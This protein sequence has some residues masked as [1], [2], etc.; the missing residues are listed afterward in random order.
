MKSN[1]QQIADA[2]ALEE[3]EYMSAIL[4]ARAEADSA[5]KQ[6]ERV[7]AS[8]GTLS[9]GARYVR[10]M[11][12][13]F[14]LVVCGV[15]TKAMAHRKKL[16]GKIPDLLSE[17]SLTGLK[18]R[19]HS[20]VDSMV[21]AQANRE[22]LNDSVSHALVQRAQQKGDTIKSQITRDLETLR[23]EARIGFHDEEKPVVLN[24]SNSTVAALNLGTVVGDLNASVQILNNEGQKD[25]AQAV[26]K[27]AEEVVALAGLQDAMRKDL[28]EHLSFISEQLAITADRRK[29]GPLKSSI[30]TLGALVKTITQL[31]P[32][33]TP[34]EHFLK[35][36]GYL[37]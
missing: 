10:E 25:L 3:N 15:A 35:I 24:I 22:T 12:I 37:T 2:L 7:M 21:K 11:E 30:E 33:W 16:G 19:L 36:H 31:A 6:N 20:L 14:D 13:R 9:S 4:A 23:L 27:F 18:L 5:I 29:V 34:I 1:H 17:A 28:L 8:R 26:E 32:L